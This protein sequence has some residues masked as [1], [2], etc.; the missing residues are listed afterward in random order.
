MFSCIISLLR[1]FFAKLE[2][3]WYLGY[4]FYGIV[5]FIGYII[6]ILGDKDLFSMV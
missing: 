3:H 2:Q 6:K 4:V 5:L 1:C